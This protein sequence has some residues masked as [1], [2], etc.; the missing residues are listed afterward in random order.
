MLDTAVV[1]ITLASLTASFV[2]AV[3]A[4]GGVY[5]ML[6][7]SVWVLPVAAA[8]PLQSAFAAASLAARI[9]YF[10]E[11]IRWP[12]AL[13]FVAGSLFGVY[14]GARTFVALPE[15]TL[16]VLLGAVLLTLIWMPKWKRPLPIRH[17]FFFV[18]VMH[19]YLG[20]LLGVGGVLQPTILRT[21][22]TKLEITGTLAV[23]LLTLDLFK[24]TAY[25]S[26]GFSYLDYIPHIVGATLAGF[27]G[28]WLGKRVTHVISEETF[29]RVFKIFVS[30]VAL[31][32]IYSGWAM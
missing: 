14:F 10:W 3:F 26:F 9:Y 24:A 4:T 19:S 31:R 22:L 32:L 27:I 7:A 8:I 11:H 16:S 28:T 29:R 1:I 20:A 2:N 6:L 23:C 21:S 18:G 12:I 17:P 25:S 13:A 5:I 30:L 15:A